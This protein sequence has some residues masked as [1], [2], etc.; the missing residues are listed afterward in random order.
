M[1][2]V[3][4]ELKVGSRLEVEWLFE[5]RLRVPWLAW[6]LRQR[7]RHFTVCDVREPIYNPVATDGVTARSVMLRF[8][9]T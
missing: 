4:S 6:A 3:I 1:L 7:H 9:A 5:E 2:K 8:T